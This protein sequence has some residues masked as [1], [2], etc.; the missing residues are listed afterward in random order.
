MSVD[1]PLL[2]ARR[3]ARR[4]PDGRRWLLDDVSLAIHPG[5][6]IALAGPSGAGKTLLLRALAM[7]D[8][9]EAGEIHWR[10][11]RVERGAIPCFR[12][13]AMYLHQR[14]ALIESTVEL[15]LERPFSL[16]V[17]RHRRF[18]ADRAV[19]FLER[20]GRDGSFLE[21]QARELSGGEIQ[22]VALARALQLE[23]CVLL[24]D[25]PTAA[26]DPATS[27][28]V[29][30]LIDEWVRESS[31]RAVVWVSHDAEQSQRVGRIHF[32]MDAGR[33]G[34]AL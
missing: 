2:E 21:K 34:P 28:A 30:D 5:Q 3:L 7:L 27:R 32:R 11:R 4:H 24:L 19:T 26:L 31:D 13:Q 8:P 1:H 12:S 9:T 33:L 10:G 14:A 16:H 20:L 22:L 25:E 23:P 15:A 29:E 17:H 18:D 6:R